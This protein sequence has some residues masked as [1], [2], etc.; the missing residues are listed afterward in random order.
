MR[1]KQ[2]VSFTILVISIIFISSAV[3]AK[4][5]KISHVRPQG[6]AID[7]DLIS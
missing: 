1:M 7:K 5:W 2:L 4:T 3:Q 6:T